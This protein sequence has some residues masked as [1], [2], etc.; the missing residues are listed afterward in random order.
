MPLIFAMTLPLAWRARA[1]LA[2]GLWVNAANAA[3]AV[4]IGVPLSAASLFV[5]W[6]CALYALVVHTGPRAFAGGVAATIASFLVVAAGAPAARPNL[7]AW[8]LATVTGMVVMR[9]IVRRRDVHAEA[10]ARHAALLDRERELHEREAV[11]EER[12]RIARELHDVVAHEV[13]LMV[14]QAGAERR[15]LPDDGGQARETLASIE[16]TGRHAL[17]ELR[18]LLGLRLCGDDG[19]P[20]APAPSLRDVGGLVERVRAVG[21][22]VTLEVAGEPREL[23]PG[24]DVSAYRIVQEALTNTVKHAGA[25]DVHVTVR[26]RS[27]GVEVDV[28]DNGTAATASHGGAAEAGGHGLIGMRE[29]AELYG[30]TLEAGPL[31][32]GG[33]GVRALLRERA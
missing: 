11:L 9:R 27:N 13:S 21:T 6:L 8:M 17:A 30:G 33:F 32:G 3:G 1:P 10:L 2:V 14:V 18:R 24:L 5:A 25:D 26:Y 15:V 20:L 22:R 23:S 28:R 16:Q 19:I 12:A 31:P 4:A 29:R 7:V